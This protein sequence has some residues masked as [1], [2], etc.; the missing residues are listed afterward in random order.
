VAD[1]ESLED[2]E[3]QVVRGGLFTHTV[4]SELAGRLGEAE[5]FLYGLIDV[6]VEGKVVD[7]ERL[8]AAAAAARPSE[9]ADE[10]AAPT[11]QIMMRVDPAEPPA[12]ALVDCATRFPVCRAVCCQLGF[13]LSAPEIEAGIVRWD[14]GRPY[15]IRH[16]QTG[17]CVHNDA[18]TGACRVYD[19]RPR[20]CRAYS[21]ANDERIW[22]DFDG[23]I[24]NEAWIAEHVGPTRPRLANAMMLPVIDAPAPQQPG[25]EAA[26]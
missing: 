16:D 18:T 1:P 7:G 5:D 22:T 13:A 14:L 2:L 12:T 21:C 4:L 15:E 11:P 17:R 24:L 23:M 19:D 3:R 26:I 9:N 6:L 20:P 10:A 25:P 8:V